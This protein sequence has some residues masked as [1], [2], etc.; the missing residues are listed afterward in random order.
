VARVQQRWVGAILVAVAVILG[1]VSVGPAGWG[2][3][4]V[5][6]VLVGVGGWHL[7]TDQDSRP[8]RGMARA[9]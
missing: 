6:A 1:A 7:L 5:L 4:A 3:G 2:F 8:R 9:R